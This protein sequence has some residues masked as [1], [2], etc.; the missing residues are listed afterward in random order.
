VE[1]R[2]HL[3]H[4]IS[5]KATILVT[6]FKPKPC[7]IKDYSDGGVY[8]ACKKS[9]VDGNLIDPLLMDPNHQ[10]TKGDFLKV[11]FAVNIKGNH[12]TFTLELEVARA[13]HDSIGVRFAKENKNAVKVLQAIASNQETNKTKDTVPSQ[14]ISNAAITQCQKETCDSLKPILLDAIEEFQTKLLERSQQATSN[15]EQ[16]LFFDAI[17][18][19]KAHKN[20]FEKS[21]LE[22][23]T[24][25]FINVKEGSATPREH[26]ETDGTLS[27]VEKDEFEDWLAIT[28]MIRQS[29]NEFELS[30]FDINQRLSQL[31]GTTIN[32]TNN[33]TGPFTICH[34]FHTQISKLKVHPQAL[35]VIYNT[36]RDHSL[37]K[38][39]DLYDTLVTFLIKVGTTEFAHKKNTGIIKK[40]DQPISKK[41][42]QAKETASSQKIENQKPT[43]TNGASLDASDNSATTNNETQDPRAII[44][45]NLEK[46][47]QMY[48]S[49]M[50]LL[51]MRKDSATSMMQQNASDQS[52]TSLKSHTV[53]TTTSVPQDRQNTFDSAP[54]SESNI[55]PKDLPDNVIAFPSE[56]M[57]PLLNQLQK[58][59]VQKIS[60]SETPPQRI[61]LREQIQK[62]ISTDPENANTQL[63]PGHDNAVEMVDRLLDAISDEPNI[64]KN[65]KP[66]IERLK[67]PLLKVIMQ[68][69]SFF[70]DENHPARK[71]V[72]HLAKMS[73]LVHTE[74]G[75]KNKNLE[76]SLNNFVDTITQEFDQSLDTF[77]DVLVDLQKVTDRQNR[78]Y[79][80][81]VERITMACEGQQKVDN[82]RREVDETLDA[83]FGGKQ[84]PSIISSLLSAGWRDLLVL[85]L[86]KEGREST[87]WLEL[88]KTLDTIFSCLTQP[89]KIRTLA[90]D[91]ESFITQLST[92]LTAAPGEQYRRHE[93]ISELEQ[94]LKVDQ[95]G[96][97]LKVASAEFVEKIT[98][99]PNKEPISLEL[100][101]WVR[102]VQKLHVGSKL[103]LKLRGKMCKYRLVWISENKERYVFVNHQGVKAADLSNAEL[104]QML[105]S[106]N[107]I[108]IEG[109]D[110]E[111][112]E[113]GLYSVVQNVYNEMAHQAT[114]DQLTRLVNR[115]EFERLTKVALADAQHNKAT[116][117]LIILDL[118]QFKVINNTCGHDAGDNLLK[119]IA[120]ILSE[121]LTEE[122]TVARLGGNEF[123]LLLANHNLEE[124][125][126][127]AE[128]KR[129]AI[130]NYRFEWE[131]Q[132]FSLTA[133]IGLIGIDKNSESITTLLKAADSTCYAAKEQGRNRSLI[134]ESDDKTL[135]RLDGMMGW[136][137]R[138]NKALEQDSLQMRCQRIQP[139]DP[140]KSLQP[141]YE[142]LLCV[143]D[144][145]GEQIP[146]NEFIE[147]A[148]YYN[149]MHSVDR[150]VIRSAFNWMQN[151]RETLQ[152]IGGFS[153][154]LSGHSLNDDSLLSFVQDEFNRTKI[155][156]NKICF[157]VT[158]TAAITNIN[159]AAELIRD[160]K[161]LGCSFALDDFGSGLS[162][163]AYLKHLPVD[164]LKIDG[165]FVKD[166]LTN[167]E[168]FAMVKS[169][170]EIG[171]FM[172]KK[173]IAEYVENDGVLEKLREI[174]VD[175]AQGYGIE[176]PR[177]LDEL[178]VA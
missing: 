54:V 23:I 74:G 18:L 174:G 126:T 60:D 142:L 45:S 178:K 100:E 161:K 135:A 123:G 133:S 106:K 164:Y 29:E 116:H 20:S 115:R 7:I 169:I 5:L 4:D 56:K 158:E 94:L 166:I 85:T 96:A 57:L 152:H 128:E 36:F 53:E 168:D 49:V 37:P 14:H 66:I 63:P 154:N 2:S 48:N 157:E 28:D 91:S 47:K 6:G 38:L 15:V 26:Q 22:N 1:R 107:A 86:L 10:I 76:R 150:W 143:V 103:E 11:Q 125:F 21:Y 62:A 156:P 149:R 139:I 13:F 160:V 27:L 93:L 159:T 140:T 155:P 35:E 109:A 34:E 95:N 3:R 61:P 138:I 99:K 144:D 117:T 113:Q 101:T 118:D 172:G 130:G 131:N 136:V 110:L 67:I 146:P 41:E 46:T 119:D 59:P 31:L 40:N 25:E 111:P 12:Q 68:D 141:H 105:K 148:E 73:Q 88:L 114:H 52:A 112:V 64:D 82:A 89:E 132:P 32:S 84:T 153:I 71:V 162:S 39:N 129:K 97:P 102:K 72:N 44:S 134:F 70:E 80:R 75:T 42:T 33:P 87:H 50:E 78:A 16:S 43:T 98:D 58:E 55:H 79:D 167:A 163:Y 17:S 51:N 92:E 90:A 145:M 151:N 81:N 19:I 8:I 120:N 165:A 124:G 127:I 122:D 30:L 108:I 121:H 147:A 65:T 171:H 176:K 24:Q 173:T 137:A 104:A 77:S 177:L 69:P 83:K 170:N 175:Y 9:I